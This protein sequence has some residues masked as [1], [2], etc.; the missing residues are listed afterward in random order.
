MRNFFESKHFFEQAYIH[1]KKTFRT[2]KRDDD[3]TFEVKNIININF[4]FYDFAE[5]N[6][7]WKFSKNNLWKKIREIENFERKIF[8]RYDKNIVYFFVEKN[9]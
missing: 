3:K 8:K 4:W 6:R 1:N 9:D 2:G 7:E 5:K